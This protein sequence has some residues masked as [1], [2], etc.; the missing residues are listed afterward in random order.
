MDIVKG[1]PVNK[2]ITGRIEIHCTNFLAFFHK[3]VFT[4]T[5]VLKI[6]MSPGPNSELAISTET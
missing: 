3:L 2:N 1:A 5:S 4:S 6:Q